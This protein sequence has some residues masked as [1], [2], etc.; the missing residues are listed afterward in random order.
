M[1]GSVA[2]GRGLLKGQFVQLAQGP[3]QVSHG[4]EFLAQCPRVSPIGGLQPLAQLLVA[5]ASAAACT[6]TVL[7]LFAVAQFFSALNIT[8][9]GALLGAGDTLPNLRYTFF[10]QWIVMLPLAYVTSRLDP[11]QL[12]GPLAA[13]ICAPILLLLLLSRR[14]RRDK[15]KKLVSQ[16]LDS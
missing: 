6:A 13:W 3:V 14:F 16:G 8:V 9:Q 2:S 11:W 10:T 4:I 7:R 15:W 1:R 5:D 12:H